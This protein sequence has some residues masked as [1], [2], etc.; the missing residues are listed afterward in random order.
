MLLNVWLI[1]AISVGY[2]RKERFM[3]GKERT[4]M[5]G[6]DSRISIDILIISVQLIIVAPT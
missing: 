2:V 4:E 1:L 3:L 6:Q 5:I